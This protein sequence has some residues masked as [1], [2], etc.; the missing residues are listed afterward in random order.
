METTQQIPPRRFG[1][2]HIGFVATL[3]VFLGIGYWWYTST[4]HGF[5]EDFVYERDAQH[6]YDSFDRDRWLLLDSADYSVEYMLKN[7]APDKNP[8]YTGTMNI[9]VGYEY[10]KFVGFTTYYKETPTSYHLLFLAIHPDFRGKGY[11]EKFLR[12]VANDVYKRGV[13]R[14]WLLTRITNY[15][16]QHLYTRVGF[17]EFKREPG[18]VFYE[19]ML[20]MPPAK[21]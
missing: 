1:L 7:K 16:A 12:Y 6:I 21:N 2:K 15:K 9:K 14:L 11:G 20:P 8:L 19:M 13:K 18:F 5:I 17:T 10:G 4:E 3:A